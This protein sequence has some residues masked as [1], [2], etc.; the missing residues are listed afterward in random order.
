MMH[1]QECEIQLHIGVWQGRSTSSLSHN[2]ATLEK[3][4]VEAKQKGLDLV[5]FP[6]LFLCGYDTSPSLIRSIARELMAA[7]DG[8]F[9]EQLRQ[10]AADSGVA[11]AVGYPEWEPA[12][13]DSGDGLIYNA[14]CIVDQTGQ[15]ILNARKVRHISSLCCCTSPP[16]F[17][18]SFLFSLHFASLRF[19]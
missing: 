10:C 14:C 17:F 18:S 8:T 5:L 13:G 11:V 12:D 6:E 15:V 19:T 1:T 3:T 7:A 9:C 2:L 4:L 16:Y